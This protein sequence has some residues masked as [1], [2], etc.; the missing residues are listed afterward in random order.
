MLFNNW[1]GLIPRP[2]G[3]IQTNY[4]RAKFSKKILDTPLLCGAV[5]VHYERITYVFNTE[6]FRMKEQQTKSLFPIRVGLAPS[7]ANTPSSNKAHARSAL[8]NSNR[9]QLL[10]AYLE[11][12]LAAWIVDIENTLLF[13]SPIAF[14]HFTDTLCGSDTRFAQKMLTSFIQLA[15]RGDKSLYY[16]ELIWYLADNFNLDTK[17]QKEVEIKRYIQSLKLTSYGLLDHLLEYLTR[18]TQAP[19]R[20]RAITAADLEYGKYTSVSHKIG[21]CFQI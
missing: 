7:T 11:A 19:D 2:L 14:N 9:G 16:K 18:L 15:Q 21:S 10:T 13:A 8:F 3:R 17:G 12:G 6:E 5:P 20:Q 4:E 1:L